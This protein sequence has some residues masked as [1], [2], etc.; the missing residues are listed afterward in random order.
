M[1]SNILFPVDFSAACADAASAVSAWAARFPARVELVHVF[2]SSGLIISERLDLT[3][4]I[5]LLHSA[6]EERLDSWL[7]EKF[8]G[9]SV[10]RTVLEGNPARQI[11]D[12]AA[13]IRADLIM[14][15]TLGYTRFRQMLLGSVTAS[16]LHDSSIPVWTNAHSATPMSAT[17]PHKIL[18]A[19]DCG[20]HTAQVLKF[21]TS[22]TATLGASLKVIHSRRAIPETFDS[23]IAERA[24]RFLVRSAAEDYAALT[25]NIPGV[26]PLE[27]LEG[28]SLI[29]DIQAAVAGEHA[30]LLI[31]GRGHMQGFLGRLRS[32][33]HD[34]IRL[35]GCPVLSI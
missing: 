4:E 22:L 6:A 2:D 12:H 24:H 5:Q 9:L 35:A 17:V 34:I 30:D 21:A 26:P 23:G 20:E 11:I 19:V 10:T 18:C 15:P 14:M 28:E 16:V 32:N 1:I 25:A 31:I 3:R 13:T 33:A 7:P 27:I 8:A 29:A